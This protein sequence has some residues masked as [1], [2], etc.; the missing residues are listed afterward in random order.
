MEEMISESDH[1][2]GTQKALQICQNTMRAGWPV[3]E[4]K[5]TK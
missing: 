5:S 2:K 3:P 4:N 1:Y